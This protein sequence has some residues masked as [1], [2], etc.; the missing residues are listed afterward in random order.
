MEES[1]KKS[2]DNL[3]HFLSEQLRK[4]SDCNNTSSFIGE[5][6]DA[7][8]YLMRLDRSINKIKKFMLKQEK[9]D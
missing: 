5:V 3:Y 8:E 1:L 6:H 7:Y 2:I 9:L 4:N